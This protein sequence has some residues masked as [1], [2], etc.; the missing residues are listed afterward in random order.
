MSQTFSVDFTMKLPSAT[1]SLFWFRI[2]ERL[3]NC[4]GLPKWYASISSQ[5][6]SRSF[7]TQS[8]RYQNWGATWYS[9]MLGAANPPWLSGN[10]NLANLSLNLLQFHINNL[11]QPFTVLIL[12]LLF[13]RTWI[14][15]NLQSS[16]GKIFIL[17]K[18]ILPSIESGTEDH[19]I[20]DAFKQRLNICFKHPLQQRN[21]KNT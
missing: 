12:L 20:V 13:S 4:N 5:T 18:E 19:L 14:I 3:A 17:I 16:Q 8:T 9:L 2:N 10:Y 11:N 1:S 15:W 21:Y 7:H 6:E